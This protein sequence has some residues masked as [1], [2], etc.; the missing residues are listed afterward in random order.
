MAQLVIRSL[1]DDVKEKLRQRASS[2]GVSLEEEARRILREAANE[3]DRAQYGLGTEIA[4]LFAD[5][6]ITE[7]IP[8]IKG[9]GFQFPELGE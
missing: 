1:D 8:E 6:G 9:G 7:D 3:P 5:F 2:H 4:S